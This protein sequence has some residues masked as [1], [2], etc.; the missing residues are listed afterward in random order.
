MVF[1]IPVVEAVSVGEVLVDDAEE[2][3][4]EGEVEILK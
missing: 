3:V 1:P 4:A 2:L